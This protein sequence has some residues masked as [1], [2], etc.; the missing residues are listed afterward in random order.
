M[1][2]LSESKLRKET[3]VFRGFMDYFP[4]AIMAVARHSFLANEKHNPGEPLHWSKGKSNDHLDCLA[5]HMLDT[6]TFDEEFGDLHDVA[7]AWRALANLQTIIEQRRERGEA[8]T[9]QD[10]AADFG[11]ETG[12][13]LAEALD[14]EMVTYLRPVSVTRKDHMFTI[15][16]PL[17]MGLGGELQGV[18]VWGNYHP[19]HDLWSIR[20][21]SGVGREYDFRINHDDV[22]NGYVSVATY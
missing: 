8:I 19:S 20:F 6:G 10:A 1:S 16:N 22:K 9:Q 4:D 11:L 21:T 15:E 7:I 5:R 2:T 3:P 18:R 12:A 13:S 17:D 14:R